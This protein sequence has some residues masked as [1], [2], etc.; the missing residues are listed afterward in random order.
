M[1]LLTDDALLSLVLVILLVTAEAIRRR[2]PH[3]GKILVTG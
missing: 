3:T 1:T 2:L